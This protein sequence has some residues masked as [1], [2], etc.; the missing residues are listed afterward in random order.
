MRKLELIAV[1]AAMLAL[2]GTAQAQGR[3]DGWG[4]HAAKVPPGQMP[5]AGMCRVWID[6]VPPGRQPA[7][8]DCATAYRTRP[9]NARVIRGSGASAFPGKGKGKA[10]RSHRRDE[11]RQYDRRDYPRG[12][13]Q[14][15][16]EHSRRDDDD[17]RYERSGR[18]GQRTDTVRSSTGSR[19]PSHTPQPTGG[20]HR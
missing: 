2:A 9:A 6:G 3:G 12:T 10:K 13:P 17:H 20:W 7:P 11:D 4:G 16:G 18:D 19:I 1:T 5:P 15:R 14:Q 8:T